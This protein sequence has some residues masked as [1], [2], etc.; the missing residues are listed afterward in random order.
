MTLLK[1]AEARRRGSFDAERQSIMKRT[2]MSCTQ[3]PV[4]RRCVSLQLP[5]WRK[6]LKKTW[7]NR[8]SLLGKNIASALLG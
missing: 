8:K 4:N 2:F 7:K 6:H 1:Y 3:L 5:N